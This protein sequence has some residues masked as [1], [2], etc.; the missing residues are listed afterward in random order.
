MFTFFDRVAKSQSYALMMDDRL[1]RGPAL[2][3][4]TGRA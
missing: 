2:P 4:T 1:E 3:V